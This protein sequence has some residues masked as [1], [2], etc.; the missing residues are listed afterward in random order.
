MTLSTFLFSDLFSDNKMETAQKMVS[1]Q[2][3]RSM[4]ALDKLRT[5]A[6]DSRRSSA[7]SGMS[8][9]SHGRTTPRSIAGR[10]TVST[11]NA[12]DPQLV[13]TAAKFVQEIIDK[14]KNEAAAKLNTET[15]VRINLDHLNLKQL[16]NIGRNQCSLFFELTEQRK[17]A[18]LPNLSEKETTGPKLIR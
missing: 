14:A 11:T 4:E 10:R 18:G 7:V 16:I 8:T 15:L 6:V 17:T 5:Y 2:K 13:D 9:G 1:I 12:P 3:Q